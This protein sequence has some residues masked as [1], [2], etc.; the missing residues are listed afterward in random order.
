MSDD[1]EEIIKTLITSAMISIMAAA[2]RALMV[3][4][5][6]LVQKAKTLIASVLMGMLMGYILRNSSLG[7][8]WKDTF[9]SC[10]AA[11]FSQVWPLLEKIFIKWL[12][13][14]AKDVLDSDG[15]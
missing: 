7:Q 8:L 1:R 5:E 13:K 15:N 4:K 10:T 14:K 9:I 2:I 12:G 11:F 3:N 6:S